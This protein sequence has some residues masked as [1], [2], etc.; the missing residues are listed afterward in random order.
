[1][2]PLSKS[3]LFNIFLIAAHD[4]GWSAILDSADTSHPFRL[5]LFKDEQSYR[6]I[7]YIW[8][9]TPGGGGR[10]VRPAGEWRIQIT[11]VTPPLALEAGRVT[12]LLGW[13]SGTGTFV[14][15]D[16]WR[17]QIWTVGSPS[18]QI[19]ESVLTDAQEVG[20][21]PYLRGNGELAIAFSAAMLPTYIEL[22]ESL[23][24]FGDQNDRFEA[25]ETAAKGITI[26]QEEILTLPTERQTVISTITRRQRESSFRSR[27][28]TAYNHRCATCALQLNLVEAAHIIPV[29]NPDSTDLTSNGLALCALH[30]RAYDGGLLA[31]NEH[32]KIL[33]NPDLIHQLESSGRVEGLDFFKDNLRQ[34]ILLPEKVSNHPKPEYLKMGMQ[35]RGWQ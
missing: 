9:L 13:H 29:Y 23:H 14:A 15:F 21:A 4:A 35:L 26:P 16:P 31:V 7:L 3:D 19:R 12:L 34:D 24:A 22:Q 20:L 28:L 27:V 25:L 18:I 30:H 5:K 6:V 11:G 1:M 33:E 17:H 2:Q 8:N 10:G 32:F